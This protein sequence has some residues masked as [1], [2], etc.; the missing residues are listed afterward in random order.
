MAF[1]RSWLRFPIMTTDE[2]AVPLLQPAIE[3]LRPSRPNYGRLHARPLPLATYPLPPLIPHNPLSLL[4]IACTY[5]YHLIA[6][7]SS[8]PKQIY[9]AHWSPET[10]SVHV[11]DEVAIRT[12]WECGFFGKGSLSRSEPNWLEREKRRK[13]LIANETSE[14]FT[15]QRREERKRFKKE[16]AKKEREAIEEK[17]KEEKL[18]T[19]N[20]HAAEP[21]AR[22]DFEGIK[23]RPIRSAAESIECLI[24]L[25]PDEP[26][27]PAPLKALETNIIVEE[28]PPFANPETK[29]NGPLQSTT[30]EIRAEAATIENQEHLQLTCSEAF[31]LV[32]GLGILRILEPNSAPIPTSTLF[33]LFRQNSYF[34]PLAPSDLQPDDPFLLSYIAYHHFRSLGWVVRAGIKFAVDWLLYLRGPVFSHAEFAV[35]VLPAYTHPYWRET[36]TRRKE[37]NKK[38]SKTWWWLHCVNRVQSQVRKSLVLVYIE[39]PPPSVLPTVMSESEMKAGNEKGVKAGDVDIGR[40]LKQYKVREL[41][42][43]R[44]IPNRERD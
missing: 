23:G 19:R 35:I 7:P 44:W 33:T 10:G 37:T 26:P 25:Q 14:D 20:G 39:V 31:F 8:H 12:V 38:E 29:R 18:S 13:G 30:R 27:S 21:T 3:S 5:V 40:F 22:A 36:D 11:I 42:M 32:Y 9:Q 2:A 17:L 6:S 34:P 24:A 43:K 16:R 28:E 15:K 1:A 4:H 41:V